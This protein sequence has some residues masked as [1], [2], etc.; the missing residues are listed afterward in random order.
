MPTRRVELFTPHKGQ[1]QI[2]DDFN[3]NNC[4]WGVV[5][6]GRQFGKTLMAMNLMLYWLY[7][8]EKLKGAWISPYNKQVEDVFSQIVS[9]CAAIIK[10]SSIQHKRIVFENESELRFLS[11][12][13]YNSIRGFTFDYGILD[14]A[15]FIKEDALKVIRP[16][17]AVNGKKV[18][19]ISTPYI[20]NWFY[21]YYQLGISEDPK[22]SNYCSYHA[23]STDNPYFPLE[24][25]EAAKETMTSDDINMEYFA[26]FRQGGGDV[27]K[28]FHYLCTV[29]RFKASYESPCYLGVDIAVTKTGDATCAVILDQFGAVV[30]VERWRDDKTSTQ[31]QRIRTICNNY[32][33]QGGFIEINTERGIQQAISSEFPLIREWMTTKK[34]KPEMIQHLRKDIDDGKLKLPSPQLDNVMYNELSSFSATPMDNGYIKYS[35]PPGGHDDSVIA[36]AL[37]NMARV[38]NRYNQFRPRFGRMSLKW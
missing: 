1:A 28:N 36:L 32:N 11:A 23:I 22:N 24:E 34:N 10:S 27:F 30:A 7:Q 26:Q 3:A 31:I 18:M 38:P 2:I 20:K 8:G 16:T 25:I 21:N 6:T 4:K 17:F 35:H 14:E 37:A 33:I 9:E 12:D 29:D 19:I 15:S 5:V 13:N